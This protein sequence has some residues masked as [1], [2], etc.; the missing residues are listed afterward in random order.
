MWGFALGEDDG[1]DIIAAHYNPRSEPLWTEPEL[2]KKCRDAASPD[3]QHPRGWLLNTE[4]DRPARDPSRPMPVFGD[5]FGDRPADMPAPGSATG[6]E[7]ADPVTPAPPSSTA[8]AGQGTELDADPA[9]PADLDGVDPADPYRLANG[10]ILARY[11]REPD[12]L[13]L[14]FWDGRFA[15][16]KAGAYDRLDEG[17]IRAELVEWTER[18]LTR[19]H[20]AALATFKRN[21][22]RGAP[23]AKKPA[24]LKV[25]RSLIG[26][27]LQALEA[28]TRVPA[29]LS[30]PC[31][32]G[33][34]PPAAEIVPC[35]NGL[36]HV[37]A[38]LAGR[39]G[40]FIPATPRFLNCA[41]VEFDF[42]PRAPA[43]V[44]WLKFL[45][46]I[47][48][49][50]ADSVACLQEWFGYLLTPDTS[51][52][53]ML[54]IVGPPRAGKGTIGRVLRA[55]V[56]PDNCAAPALGKLGDRFALAALL[57]KT[58]AILADA[59]LSGR[60]DSVAIAEELLGIS[61]EDARTADLK[62]K[63]PVTTT[64]RTRF[65]FFS[66]ELPRFGDSSGAIVS[67]FVFLKLVKSFKGIEDETLESRLMPELPGI[68]LWA[69][70]G[71]QRLQAQGRFTS[72]ESS[73]ELREDAEALAS[74]VSVWADDCCQLDPEEWES[75]S[76][77][78]NSWREWCDEHGR[79]RPG[80]QEQ[81]VR[82]MLAALPS[83]QKSRKR[84]GVA[85]LNGYQGI[86]V[87]SK[88][89]AG[90]IPI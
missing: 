77:L 30:P 35:R 68:L 13:T 64:L 20:V 9:P 69:L 39:A 12:G 23:A 83:L 90:Q 56:G 85:R 84:E 76:N 58:V 36:V 42:D 33:A 15:A 60:A 25:T 55:L 29:H 34:G 26:D 19:L 37:P 67:R 52:H 51:R 66:N 45:E 31:W 1:Y 40:S 89:E 6:A 14:R 5:V 75:T 44:E 49:G 41:R 72:P 81:F 61:G 18:E 86:R 59:R 78:F 27:A 8:G 3:F 17:A 38:F 32:I 88:Y 28:I 50:E 80:H 79:D 63:S 2:R 65:V 53:K 57:D 82:D 7:L 74:P 24:K 54:M 11:W 46:S 22:T 16:W 43:P 87:M 70:A 73:Q 47:W 62:F 48:P 21:E 71:W 10:F 4:A